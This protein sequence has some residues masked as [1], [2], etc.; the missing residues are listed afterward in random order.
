MLTRRK[1][2]GGLGLLI[3]APTII[4]V[5]DMMPI[6]AFADKPLFAKRTFFL[7]SY[8]D[9]VEAFPTEQMYAGDFVTLEQKNGVLFASRANFHSGE[10]ISARQIG[11]AT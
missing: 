5:A 8:G 4:R 6:K 3:A 9:V 2:I 1:L 7:S 10:Y 11:I